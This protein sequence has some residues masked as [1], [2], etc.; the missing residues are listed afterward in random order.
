M[1]ERQQERGSEVKR[2]VMLSFAK[3]N[4]SPFADGP[5]RCANG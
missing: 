4:V 5:L 2:V 3:S 1:S